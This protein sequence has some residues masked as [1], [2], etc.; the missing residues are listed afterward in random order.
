MDAEQSGGAEAVATGASIPSFFDPAVQDDPF[1]TYALMHERC[2][3]HRLPE[4]DLYMVS[5]HADVHTVLA[6]P[7]T[8]SNVPSRTTGRV[9]E[10]IE[11]H[12]KV[13]TRSAAGSGPRRSSART[14]RCILTTGDC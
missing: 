8:F 11:E 12:S 7:A 13:F 2:P 14:L 3:V 6:D 4:N 5:R 9:S 10:A 1:E